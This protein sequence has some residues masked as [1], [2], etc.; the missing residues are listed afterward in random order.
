MKPNHRNPSFHCA[1]RHAHS[2]YE[3]LMCHLQKTSSY[4]PWWQ[5]ASYCSFCFSCIKRSGS[6]TTTHSAMA[7][8]RP[9][10][11]PPRSDPCTY[12]GPA[13]DPNRVLL[14]RF[15]YLNYDRDMCR[16]DF[17]R[18]TIISHWS[19][20]V[21]LGF[22][23]SSYL[24]SMSNFGRTT[25]RYRGRNV[26]ERTLCGSLRTRSL[27]WTAQGRTGLLDLHTINTGSQKSTRTEK[28]TIHILHDHESIVYVHRHWAMFTLM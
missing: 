24:P 5:D 19:S 6:A 2:L 27:E 10:Q 14:L 25:A 17:T 1:T 7:S 21:G 4:L 9:T 13:F 16:S 8:R 15:L 26:S 22:Y 28:S 23:R 3:W 12:V 11:Q 18:R 20:L